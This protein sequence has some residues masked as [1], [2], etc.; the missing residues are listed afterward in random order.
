MGARR[1]RV[2]EAGEAFAGVERQYSGTLGKVGNCQIGVSVHAVGKRG[3]A[4]LGWA[5][6]LP[7]EWAADAARR[8]KARIPESV[9]FKT[10]PELGVELVERAAGWGLPAVPVLGDQAYG[11]NTALRARVH[12]AG[13]EY[14]LA[15]GG[16]T[17]VFAPETVFE[18]P[19]PTGER[20]RPKSRPQPDREPETI[21]GLVARLRHEALALPVSF[22]DGPDGKPTRGRVSCSCVYGPRTTGQKSAPSPP[23]GVADR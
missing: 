6:Y 16:Q 11:D 3:T 2:P 21:R 20:G 10:K 18:V 22:R 8:T 7:E 14:V 17:K 9:T 23:R 12:A 15:V 4:P 5:L 13:R 19:D 1:H